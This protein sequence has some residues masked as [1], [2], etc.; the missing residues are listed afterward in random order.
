MARAPVPFSR[1]SLRPDSTMRVRTLVIALALA[2]P[3]L[4]CGSD[5]AE[6]TNCTRQCESHKACGLEPSTICADACRSSTNSAQRKGCTTQ[7]DAYMACL[8]PDFC[9]AQAT[10]TAQEQAFTT[11]TVESRS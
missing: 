8:Q 6:E 5:E 11:C 1:S 3:V 10:C 7:F 9:K 2:V 4:A